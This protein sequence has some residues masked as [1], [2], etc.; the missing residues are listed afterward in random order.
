MDI[1]QSTKKGPHLIKLV[2]SK[3]QQSYD[4]TDFLNCYLQWTKTT[5]PWELSVT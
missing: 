1:N 2:N 4:Y 5:L 3:K